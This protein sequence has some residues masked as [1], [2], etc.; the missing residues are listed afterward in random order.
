MIPAH[1]FQP[2]AIS[3]LKDRTDYEAWL[4]EAVYHI[5]NQ[6]I[7]VENVDELVYPPTGAPP[8]Q[9]IYGMVSINIGDWRPGFL[10]AG[11]PLVL[12]TAFKLIDMLLEW[13][14]S[15]NGV[16]STFRFAQKLAALRG[17]MQFPPLIASRPWL[18][19]RLVA[20]YSKLEPLRG[21]IIH[22]RHFQT[23][24]GQLQVSPSKGGNVQASVPLSAEDLRLLSVFGVSLLRYLEG[25]WTLDQFS[26]KRLRYT[27]DRL[28][29]IHCG[30]LLG[31]QEPGFLNVRLYAL[32]TNTI[33]LDLDR[34]RR[35]AAARRPGQDV[36]FD[37]R[38][39]IVHPDGSSARSFL[40]PWA[41]IQNSTSP[42]AV[43]LQDLHA[44]ECGLPGDLEV[45]EV[46]RDLGGS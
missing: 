45:R 13:M 17:P 41:T 29:H 24:A 23:S 8:T 34:V 7:A 27:L 15:E 18:Q 3:D 20:L 11:A 32:E 10:E 4:L 38:L 28:A 44:F 35:D 22:D 25:T 5:T 9:T 31:Q 6:R 46:A 40:V 36:L 16:R 12:V 39:V 30:Q 21:T 26:E 33:T 19:D 1:L 2:A 14:L 37:L 43:A 42:F